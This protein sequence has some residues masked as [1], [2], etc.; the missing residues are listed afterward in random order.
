MV[1]CVYCAAYNECTVCTNGK[2]V[3]EL[4][5]ACQGKSGKQE[6]INFRDCSGSFPHYRLDYRKAPNFSNLS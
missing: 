6:I 5:D 1:D 4:G 2:V 3:T